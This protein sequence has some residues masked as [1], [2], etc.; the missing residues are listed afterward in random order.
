MRLGDRWLLLAPPRA[1][2]GPLSVLVEGLGVL[3]PG[4]PAH[5]A[6]SGLHVG[7]A[8]IDLAGARVPPRAEV[9]PLHGAW[10]SALAAA[11]RSCPAPGGLEDGVDALRRGALADAVAVLA[12][13][14]PGLTPAGDDV[15]AGFAGWRHADGE[16][17]SLA[18][19]RGSPIGLAYLRLRRAG[20]AA[21]GRAAHARRGPRRRRGARRSPRAGPRALGRD[22][23]G[24]DAVRHGRGERSDVTGVG[25]NFIARPYRGVSVQETDALDAASLREWLATRRV[26]RRTEFIVA[27]AGSEHAVVQVERDPGDGDIL[28]G[29][30]A[31][32]V[33]AAPEEVAFVVDPSV[34]TGN[35]TQ[36][37]RA[38][39]ASGRSAR[40]Y[41]VQGRFE[42]V[43]FIVEPSPVVVR[44]VE[45]VPPEPPKLLEMARAVVDFDEDL[46]PVELAFEP[47]DLRRLAA[48]HP[49][50]HYLFPCRCSGLDADVPVDFLDAGPPIGARRGRSSAASARGRSTS[51][52]TGPSRT[53]GSTSA[54]ARVA[55]GDGPT[56]MKCC[57]RERGIERAGSTTIVPWGA[58]LEEVRQALRRLTG[59]AAP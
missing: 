6:S 49:A 14:G 25:P 7:G 16:P 27:A 32:H 38:A 31:V 44:V 20:R 13:R 41:V 42:H 30:R 46:P 15:L 24:R 40:V 54:R 52:C 37:A 2:L 39:L 29:V 12:G 8:W 19:P 59:V 22:V 45:V 33:L 9:V 26:Y 1:P 4:A 17:V 34:D 35:A 23:G 57:L 53:H 10:R 43:N 5:V 48:A 11:R 18:S 36:M 21:R 51:P 58:T 47:I 3:E 56:L 55:G 28:V 50:G